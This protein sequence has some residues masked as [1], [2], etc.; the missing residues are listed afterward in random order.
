MGRRARMLGEYVK[1]STANPTGWRP[2]DSRLSADGLAFYIPN[3][4]PLPTASGAFAGARRSAN[5]G[6][7]GVSFP[8]FASFAGDR[9]WRTQVN[10]ATPQPVYGPPPSA[11]VALSYLGATVRAIGPSRFREQPPVIVGS[12]P[13]S[14]SSAAPS[15]SSTWQSGRQ[16]RQRG[17][18]SQASNYEGWS[19]QQQGPQSWQQYQQQQAQQQAQTGS[20]TGAASGGIVGYDAS[21]NPIYATPPAGLVA[22][23]TD[24]QGNPVY[25]A[26]GSATA[27]AATTSSGS[28]L[29]EDSLGFGLPNIAYLGIGVGLVLIL[30]KR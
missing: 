24:A 12:G 25:G 6:L 9:A 4:F 17:S 20:M 22:T 19:A 27:A 8:N 2:W 14:A 21:G 23:G 5:G 16:R 7:A 28:I 13:V 15:T 26:A 11:R 30:K 18:Q 3:S 1:A 10:P 29:T